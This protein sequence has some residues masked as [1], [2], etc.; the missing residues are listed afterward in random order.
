LTRPA[1]G[2]VALGTVAG[3]LFGTGGFG[4]FMVL[5]NFYDEAD[6]Q[7]WGVVGASAVG[8]ALVVVALATRGD[9]R[10]APR[11]GITSRTALVLLALGVAVTASALWVTTEEFGTALVVFAP[12]S[13][14]LV[15]SSALVVAMPVLVH[16]QARL[17]LVSVATAYAYLAV[18][19]YEVVSWLG[20]NDALDAP[21]MLIVAGAAVLAVATFFAGRAPAPGT[22]QAGP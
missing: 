10:P 16:G 11:V 18:L 14:V 20:R 21:T 1:L 8:I 17:H 6:R 4:L 12:S 3:G 9:L 22:Q 15:T 2:S 5:S 19:G 7:W 13:L